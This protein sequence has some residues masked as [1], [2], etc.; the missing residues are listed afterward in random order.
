VKF[1]KQLKVCDVKVNRKKL[2]PSKPAH[3]VIH[4][5]LHIRATIQNFN[6]NNAYKGRHS[7]DNFIR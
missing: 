6:Q 7:I 2:L 3:N 1:Q 4:T 5:Y